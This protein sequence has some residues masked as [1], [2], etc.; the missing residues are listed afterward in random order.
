MKTN[1]K[2]A[3]LALDIPPLVK[4]Q[5]GKN[6][7]MRQTTLCTAIIF[8]FLLAYSSASAEKPTSFTP[9]A[10]GVV[11]VQHHILYGLPLGTP[12]TN[13]LIAR[14]IYC[15]SNN[16]ETKFADWVAY[17]LDEKSVTG[18][19]AKKRLWKPDPSLDK[20]ATL[21]PTDYKGAHAALM[22]D[23]GHQAPLASFKGTEY[24]HQTNYLSN[25]TPQNKNLNQGPWKRLEDKIRE[26]A[27][28]QPIYVM[29]GPLYERQMAMLPN[30]DEA[31]QIPSGYWKIVAVQSYVNQ[32][33][34]LV[35]FIFD[36]ETARG[37]KFGD[38]LA[39]VNDIEARSG[40]DFFWQL[41]DQLEETIEGTNSLSIKQK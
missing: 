34:L 8:A 1:D 37:A 19:S 26:L 7:I 33:I 18:P 41:P 24:W 13:T 23:R 10:N 29:T 12:A 16:G 28:E 21:E 35:G 3:Y 2:P 40:L 6:K 15:M 17:R 27:A 39:T 30:A 11:L 9:D 20:A 36:Q 22:T 4:N 32:P 38:H 31:H 14:Q 25:I 5:T